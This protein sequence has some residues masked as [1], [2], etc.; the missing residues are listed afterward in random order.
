MALSDSRFSS[1]NLRK[2]PSRFLILL[3]VNVEQFDAIYEKLYQLE[4]SRQKGRHCLWREERVERLVASNAGNLKEYLC[5]TLL[6]LR[7]Y[8][9]QESLATAFRVSQG[10]ISRIIDN[11]SKHLEQ[12]L[13]TPERT[14]EALAEAVRQI[15]PELRKEYDATLIVDAS[16]QR[17]E[18]NS[19]KAKQREEYSGKKSVIVASSK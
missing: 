18:R 10:L 16:E 9:I 4:L 8:Q 6:Y 2:T 17:I 11:T 14:T 19:D 15:N 12:I 7:Q 5:I 13:P 1:V 3:G